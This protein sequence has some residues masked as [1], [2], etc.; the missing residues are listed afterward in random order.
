MILNEA[1]EEKYRVQKKLSES[2]SDIHEYF[3]KSHNSALKA[4]AKIGTS[5]NYQSLPGKE[6][7]LAP[8]AAQKL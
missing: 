2:V 4:L 8:F 5:P 3:E 6:T 7:G 1:L